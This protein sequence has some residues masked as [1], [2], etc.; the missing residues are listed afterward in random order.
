MTRSH[1]IDR[2]R[3]RA[4]RACVLTATLAAA[5]G[6][7]SRP[8]VQRPA[9]DGS[10]TF[11]VDGANGLGGAGGAAVVC[12]P[13][14][15]A[16]AFSLCGQIAGRS[17]SYVPP[18]L[19]ISA[20]S[21]SMV[22]LE[23]YGPDGPWLA[24]WG[25]GP[26]AGRWTDEDPR[27][28]AGWLLKPPSGW[29]P[30]ASWFCGQAGTMTRH[31]DASIDAT[32]SEPALLPACTGAG[33]PD[34]LQ[35]DVNGGVVSLGGSAGCSIGFATND[36]RIMILAPACP[37]AGVALPLD[38][39]RVVSRGAASY[40]TACIGVGASVTFIPD[41][42]TNKQRLIVDVPSMSAPETCGPTVGGELQMQLRWNGGG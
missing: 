24:I 22:T 38:G 8:L 20:R 11:G 27:P 21:V 25:A 31:G 42:S 1:E 26:D 7:S 35:V 5:L 10:I 37:Q 40:T 19:E 28:V 12:E 2:A 4:R 13:T 34:S 15:A 9:G 3:S 23:A 6:C 33:G 17:V 39:L 18:F 32:L 29:V 36:A 14:D 30:D 41:P 16:Q